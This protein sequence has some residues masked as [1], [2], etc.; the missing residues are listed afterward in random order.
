MTSFV[1]VDLPLLLPVVMLLTMELILEDTAHLDGIQI[2]QTMMELDI[3]VADQHFPKLPLES[4]LPHLFPQ[5]LPNP[6]KNALYQLQNTMLLLLKMVKHQFTKS[7][8][9]IHMVVDK[10]VF[11]LC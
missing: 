6:S 5:M 7:S 2:T 11:I 3:D 10:L 1:L 9:K 4:L 8:K